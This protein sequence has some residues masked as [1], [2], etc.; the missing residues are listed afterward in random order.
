MSQRY[1]FIIPQI[2]SFINMFLGILSILMTTDGHLRLA[3][4]LIILAA[5]MD[6]YDGRIARK[7]NVESSFGASLDSFADLISFGIAPIIIAWKLGVSHIGWFGYLSI[8]IFPIAATFRLARYNL[9]ETERLHIGVPITLAAS[10]LAI[11]FLFDLSAFFLAS[12]MIILALL[13]IS[14]VKIKKF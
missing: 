5:I 3:S 8:L 14:T 9:I 10:I 7:F 11:M 12:T 2:L 1:K 13:M 6:R 4:V